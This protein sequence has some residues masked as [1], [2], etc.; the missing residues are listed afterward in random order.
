MEK[1]VTPPSM[2][3]YIR[4]DVVSY[5]KCNKVFHGYAELGESTK[6]WFYGFKLHISEKRPLFDVHT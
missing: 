1:E 4:A 5:N 6:G 3:P 2:P